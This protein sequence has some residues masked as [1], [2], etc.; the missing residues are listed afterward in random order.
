MELRL[1]DSTSFLNFAM[2][3]YDNPSC[4]TMDDF[5]DDLNRLLYIKK[6]LI[7]I[8]AGE[9]I[10]YLLIINHFIILLNVFNSTA[11]EA[12][13][14]SKIDK[15]QWGLLKT[16]LDHFDIASE[17]VAVLGIST[18]NIKINNNIKEELINAT[19]CR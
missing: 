12:M 6:L 1:F 19:N 17:F 13:L 9:K 5:N 2:K 14:Y 4:R 11:L 10:D 7:R 16:V 15:E 18:H 3:H 8:Q